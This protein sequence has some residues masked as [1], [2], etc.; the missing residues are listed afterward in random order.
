MTRSVM[1]HALDLLC[2]G[3]ADDQVIVFTRLIEK[4]CDH[5]KKTSATFFYLQLKPPSM[6]IE[7][8][9]VLFKFYN[10]IILCDSF[11]VFKRHLYSKG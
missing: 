10:F 8:R 2:T 6:S 1:D 7:K 4:T 9:P 3:E 5:K 11:V